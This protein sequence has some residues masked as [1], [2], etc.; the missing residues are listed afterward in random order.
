MLPLYA[1]SSELES[2]DALA[3]EV[4]R[5]STYQ[6]RYD[7]RPALDSDYLVCPDEGSLNGKAE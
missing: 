6:I 4:T 2:G 3:V 7:V 5:E 1:N